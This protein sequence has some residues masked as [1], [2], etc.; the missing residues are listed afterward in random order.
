MGDILIK[1]AW[2]ITSRILTETFLSK[3][4]IYSLYS[5]S[6]N[7]ANTLDDKMVDALAEALAVKDYKKVA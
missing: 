2:A 6:K 5:L 4:I 7:T 1:L 3:A